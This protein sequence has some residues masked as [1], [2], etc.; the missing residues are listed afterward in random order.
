MLYGL[1]YLVASVASELRYHLWT[2]LAALLAFTIVATEAGARR[3][4]L[5]LTP[6]AMAIAAGVLCRL[7]S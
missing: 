3:R 6:A 4:W 2:E 1:S 5:A 7:A